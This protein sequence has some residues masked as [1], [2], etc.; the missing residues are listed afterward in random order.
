[1]YLNI[2]SSEVGN[3][4][5]SCGALVHYLEK[6]NR[7][8][9]KLEE[10]WYNGNHQDIFPHEVR[11]QIDSNV[12][13]L[14]KDD[15]KFFLINI[16]PSQKEIQHL[17]NIYGEDGVREVLKAYSV[18]LMDSYARNFKRNGVSGQQD[19]LWFAKVEQ[20][21]YYGYQDKEVKSGGRKRGDKK[22]GAHW[23]VQVIVSRKDIT[24]KIKLSPQNTSK[25]TNI[26][27]SQKLG[28]F[29]RTAF[30]E[31]GEYLFD[32]MF[33]FDRG[34]KDKMSYADTMKNGSPEQRMQMKTLAGLEEKYSD[35]IYGER[36]NDLAAE[37][38]QGAFLDTMQ[39]LSVVSGFGLGVFSL[40]LGE[41]YEE[42]SQETTLSE[43][44]RLRRLKR[45]K[46]GLR[47]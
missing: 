31:S 10:R 6:E 28:Q 3:N 44:E 16:S 41:D 36:L 19:L 4:K 40:L 38:R 7:E 11:M 35:V 46:K 37:I 12:A 20:F 8:N 15:S 30:K 5:G 26:Q 47:R 45:K 27:H 17:I 39:L 22:E 43:Q 21:R 14:S 23:H 18:G 1:M 25:G 29:D 32:E 42:N 2:T 33:G 24:N 34:L 9:P 13:K